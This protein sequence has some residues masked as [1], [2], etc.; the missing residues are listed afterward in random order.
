[1]SEVI[2]MFKQ[3]R[4]YSDNFINKLKKYW[5]NRLNA[6]QTAFNAI[7]DFILPLIQMYQEC[8][9]NTKETKDD[10]TNSQK[11]LRENSD[12]LLNQLENDLRQQINEIQMLVSEPEIN[13]QVATCKQILVKIETEYRTYYDKAIEIYDQ[14]QPKI[15]QIFENQENSLLPFVK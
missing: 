11:I 2:P 6:I 3:C 5:E 12:E 7:K 14:Q 9:S 4:K 1:M 8:V 13:N 15:L 10:V